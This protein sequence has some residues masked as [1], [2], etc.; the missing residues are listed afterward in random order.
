MR[1]TH[2][3]GQSNPVTA[4]NY[5]EE[6]GDPAGGYAHGVGMSIA[7][8]DGPRGKVGGEL[9]PATGAF[10]EDALV[11][12]K[13]RLQFFQGSKY[14]HPANAAAIVLIDQAIGA[15]HERAMER[16]SRGVL[17]ANAV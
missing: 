4:R 5:T 9:G 16:A 14:A 13:Q 17:G 12:A 6:N 15:L 1:Q 8:Q 11:A 7:W 10:V 3:H 2:Q